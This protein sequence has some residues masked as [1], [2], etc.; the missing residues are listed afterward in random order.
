M[1]VYTHIA[2]FR[3]QKGSPSENLVG[4]DLTIHKLQAKADDITT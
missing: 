3:L 2:F 4:L 1:G